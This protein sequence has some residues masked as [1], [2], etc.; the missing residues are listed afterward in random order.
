MS[1]FDIREISLNRSDLAELDAREKARAAAFVFPADR[2]RYQ[3]AHVMLRRVL[4]RPPGHRSA[5]ASPSAASAV[6]RAGARQASP[7]WLYRSGGRPPRAPTVPGPWGCPLKLLIPARPWPSR[8]PRG[9][10]GID[11]EREA[12]GRAA[13]WPRPCT[14]P[15][16]RSWRCCRN[17]AASRGDPLVGAGRGG[18]V[19]CAGTGIAHGMD[20]FPVLGAP[21]RSRVPPWAAAAVGARRSR[22]GR[23]G[24]LP[25]RGTVVG[26]RQGL[27]G[28]PGPARA[29][30]HPYAGG[31]DR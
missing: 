7:C 20:A 3:V 2:H 18:V 26:R 1:W 4:C 17:L 13:R 11:V 12:T 22:L 15:T 27:P 5:A 28:G 6:P 9:P 31:P 8:W 19:K 30:A 29:A 14:R 10:V 23:R 16:P 25:V 21:V 24:L